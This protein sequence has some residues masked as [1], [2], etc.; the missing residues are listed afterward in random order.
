MNKTKTKWYIMGRILICLVIF[1]LTISLIKPAKAETST[2][3]P[4]DEAGIAAYVKLDSTDIDIDAVAEAFYSIEASGESYIIGTVK[5]ENEVSPNYPHL[6]VGL[7]GW[8]VAYYLKGEE[9]SRMMQWKN[10]T[11]GS[12]N[13]NT[14]KDAIDYMS[15]KIG[16]T[17][18]E[19]VKYYDFEFP[20]ANK[21]TLIA[22]SNDFYVTVPGTLY[23][24]SYGILLK[25]SCCS[26]FRCRVLKL[27]IDENLV[28]KSPGLG[29]W[30][31]CSSP[32]SS[33]G[34]YDLSTFTAGITH[35]IIFYNDCSDWSPGSASVTVLIY[36]N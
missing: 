12:I 3:F 6:Y 23:E 33:Y 32:F 28:Y 27:K 18:S 29:C 15:G 36:K 7:D 22:D 24:A 5:V 14:L 4:V 30:F 9:A 13:T 34:Y 16:I 1:S 17:Y 31:T 26:G 2:T 8:L 20:E 35:Y 11:V 19:P 10:Y 25:D 21:M